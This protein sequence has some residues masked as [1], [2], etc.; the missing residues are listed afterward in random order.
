MAYLA[1]FAYDEIRQDSSNIVTYYASVR[2]QFAADLGMEG[3]SEEARIAA[4]CTVVAYGMAPY[5]DSPQTY[6]LDTLLA[7]PTLSCAHYVAVA[8][9]FIEEFGIA[10]DVQAAVGWDGG[11]VGNHAQMLFSDG[12]TDLLL[13][14]TIG[15]IVK[16]VTYEGLIAGVAYDEMTSFYSRDDISSF[17]YLVKNALSTGAY[18][19]RDTIYYVPSLDDWM[20]HQADYMGIVLDDGSTQTIVGYLTDDVISGSA[21]VDIIYGGK[22]ND[23]LHL[24]G[25]NDFGYGGLGDDIIYG[26]DSDDFLYGEEGNDYLYGGQGVDSAVFYGPR[27]YYKV[28]DV[29]SGSATVIGAHGTDFLFGMEMVVFDDQIVPLTMSQRIETDTTGQFAWSSITYGYDW[30]SRPLT[31]SYDYDDGQ[32]TIYSYDTMSQHVWGSIIYKYNANDLPVSVLYNNDNGSRVLYEYDTTYSQSWSRIETR[33]DDQWN[34]SKLIYTN[35][36]GTLDVYLYDV[37]NTG[38]WSS[39]VQRH[40]ASQQKITELY[41]MDDGTK[42]LYNYDVNNEFQWTKAERWFDESLRVLRDVI[43]LDDGNYSV[44]YYDPADGHIISNGLY[45]NNWDQIA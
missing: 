21:G 18:E 41:T 7:S 6:D 33:Y 35:Y 17:D 37:D 27:S 20:T 2:D 8:W 9:Q 45:S 5:G 10:T 24:L 28:F 4:F 32:S 43:T 36:D 44:T 31:V 40:D 19:V 14:P 29:G 30:K 15:L 25:G 34:R 1:Q 16:D 3:L 23:T 39:V 11:A 13:D 12:T 26:G 42:F 22:G 38:S